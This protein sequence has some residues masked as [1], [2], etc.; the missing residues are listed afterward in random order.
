MSFKL[1][2]D[3]AR[4][5]KRH[6][7]L[8]ICVFSAGVILAG[9][10]GVSIFSSVQKINASNKEYET[11]LAATNAMEENNASIER[12]LEDNANMDE[13]IEGIA[14]DKLD[15]ATPDERVYYIVP[16]ST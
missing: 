10:V 5:G 9:F 1:V 6:G 7:F 2:S 8:K 3:E 16:S 13:Y 15:F 4:E 11:Y 14:R 12:Y